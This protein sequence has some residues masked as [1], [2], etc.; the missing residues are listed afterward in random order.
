MSNLTTRKIVLGLLMVLVLTFS[1]QG[2]ADALTSLR[3]ATDDSGDGAIIRVSSSGNTFVF[4]V[5]GTSE[6]DELTLTLSRGT[7]TS[8]TSPLNPSNGD[9]TVFY[10]APDTTMGITLMVS[11][12]AKATGTSAQS[13][14]SF[15]ATVVGDLTLTKSKNISTSRD[16]QTQVENRRLVNPLTFSVSNVADDD[17]FVIGS[18]GGNWRP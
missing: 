10:N 14:I 16:H 18:S 5:A 17:S 15:S 11:H 12:T 3:K 6:D 13:Q 1:V 8:P 7:I 4:T 2:I 9:V